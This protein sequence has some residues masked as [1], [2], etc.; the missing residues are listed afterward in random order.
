M[1]KKIIMLGAIV[2]VTG[3]LIGALVAVQHLEPAPPEQSS[4]IAST[5][6]I[7]L[8]GSSDGTSRAVTVHVKNEKGEFKVIDTKPN[9]TRMTTAITIEGFEGVALKGYD[10]MGVADRASNMTVPSVI[11]DAGANLADFGLDKPR[12]TI[13]ITYLDNT[14]ARLLLGSNA[15]GNS[16]VYAMKDGDPAVYMLYNTSADYFLRAPTDFID[17]KI[18][19]GDSQETTIVKAVLGGSLRPDEIVIEEAPQKEEDADEIIASFQTH[20]ITAPIKARLHVMQ[21]LNHLVSVFGLVAPKVE[22]KLESDDELAKYGLAEPYS[23]IAIDSQSLVDGST[24]SFKLLVSEPDASGTCFVLREGT[25][26]VFALPKAMLPWLELNTFNMM[27]KMLILPYIDSV[28]KIEIK[29]PT[30]TKS[31]TLD[32]V[33]DALTVQ[34]D[35][36]PYED[37]KNF[38]QFYQT[39]LAA[40]YDSYTDEA[41]PAGAK[42]LLQFSYHY[43]DGSTPTTITFYEGAARKVF[44]QLNDESPMLAVSSYVDRIISDLNKIVTGATVSSY[45]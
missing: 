2:L 43:R 41:I 10:L 17:P 36:Q 29:T 27:D 39:L 37:V 19:S 35:G 13:D 26:V 7:Y 34:L 15:P 31:F 11:A 22:A 3:L 1:S 42:Q 32:G 6:S 20:N 40:S 45:Y 8:L 12:I 30:E 21:G 24:E 38:R 25:P 23:T 33:E 4:S 44:I 5:P 16:G 28:G 18:T 14:S 9:E